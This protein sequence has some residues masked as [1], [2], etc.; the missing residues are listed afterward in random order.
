M[1]LLG[2]RPNARQLDIL[3]LIAPNEALLPDN[4]SQDFI[5]DSQCDDLPGR[6]AA[7]AK[8]V[9]EHVDVVRVKSKTLKSAGFAAD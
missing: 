3:Q 2:G 6:P 1:C 5:A 4:V 8:R 7:R 9:R